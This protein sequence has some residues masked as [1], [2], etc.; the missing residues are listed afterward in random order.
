MKGRVKVLQQH[1][2]AFI[3]YRHAELDSKIAKEIHHQL[4]HFRIPRAIT[5]QTGIKKIDR[6]FR[7]KEELPITS[8]L[9]DDITLALT[10]ADYLIVICS[11]RTKESVWVQKEIETFLISHSRNRVLTVLVEGEPGDVIPEIL[12]NDVVVDE[13]TGIKKTVP[14]EPLSCDYRMSRRKARREE[15]PRLAAAILDCAYDA[16]RQRQK[17][18]RTQRLMAAMAALLLFTVSMTAYFIWS[19]GQIQENY[20]MALENQSIYLASESQ[21]ALERGDRV[22]AIQ[23]A[24][25][26]MPDEGN[27]RPLTTEAELALS[28]AVEAYTY[29]NSGLA[30]AMLVGRYY[31]ST[32]IENFWTNETYD[33]LATVDQQFMVKVWDVA[34]YT[35]L[36]HIQLN[37]AYSSSFHFLSRISDVM[38]LSMDRLLVLDGERFTCYDFRTGDVLW[39]YQRTSEYEANP[40]SCVLTPQ[41]DQLFAMYRSKLICIDTSFGTVQWECEYPAYAQEQDRQLSGNDIKILSENAFSTDG[42]A[43]L[44]AAKVN[45]ETNSRWCGLCLNLDEQ[46]WEYLPMSYFEILDA[47]MPDRGTA[48]ILGYLEDEERAWNIYGQYSNRESHAVLYCENL[49]TT[50]PLWTTELNYY[51]GSLYETVRLCDDGKLY[52]SIA[53]V[54]CR[55]NP[56]TG[57]IIG[58]NEMNSP[59]VDY[60]RQNSVGIQAILRDGSTGLYMFDQNTISS[61]QL[62]DAEIQK[63]YMNVE[64]DASGNSL[65]RYFALTENSE[66]IQ[67]YLTGARMDK[68][69]QPLG[70]ELDYTVQDVFQCE[71]HLIIS[72]L[73]AIYMIDSQTGTLQWTLNEKQFEDNED[74]SRLKL[75][76]VLADRTK[77]IVQL[78]Y[79]GAILGIVDLETG[80]LEELRLDLPLVWNRSDACQLGDKLYWLE[81]DEVIGADRWRVEQLRCFDFSTG[82]MDCRVL[83]QLEDM[84]YSSS[85]WMACG[86]R[87]L[88]QSDTANL[89]LDPEELAITLIQY[90]VNVKTVPAVQ[91]TVQGFLAYADSYD[92]ILVDQAGVAERIIS[93]DVPVVSVT[94]IPGQDALLALGTNG[95]VYAYSLEGERIAVIDLG[96][97]SNTI[98]IDNVRWQ[99][100]SNGQII[101]Y[102]NNSE[103]LLIN[104]ESWK[105]EADIDNCFYVQGN[106]FFCRRSTAAS[107]SNLAVVYTRYTPEELMQQGRELVGDLTLLDPEKYG[108]K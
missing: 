88:L 96:L 37:A 91:D 46:N 4:E 68:K 77:L 80:V 15:L 39:E 34:T 16:L 105:L 95:Q 86:D 79:H 53:N 44:F 26:A 29:Q 98:S 58:R 28:R 76:G 27:D 83:S 21:Q 33:L 6:I 5:K 65:K 17:L 38:V 20:R 7:D 62:F 94:F 42:S 2:N 52:C 66:S 18:Y 73:S 67:R 25:A 81:L 61:Y 74:Y 22:T 102:C 72:T 24:M 97:N 23:L 10:D 35:D 107:G 90:E 92:V 99:F 100:D 93:M 69:Y 85:V 32:Q 103:A 1:Y 84:V 9:N 89:L 82:E 40:W 36:W 54:C 47:C 60:V 104:Q 48:V 51:T 45:S 55:V 43:V 50:E 71:D 78:D 8:D 12:L 30:G 106:R 70:W 59:V 75:L 64:K 11:P 41:G 87:I 19:N 56:E 31:N 3:S 49:Q 63:V 108:L 101:L 13:G 14:V 57:E